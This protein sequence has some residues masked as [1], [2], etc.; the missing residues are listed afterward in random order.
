MDPA[1]S[2][3]RGG[4]FCSRRGTALFLYRFGML[5]M[6]FKRFKAILVGVLVIASVS[7]C[8]V[9]SLAGSVASVAIDVTGAVVVTGI[10]AT[11]AAIDVVAGD[12]D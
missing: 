6:G 10:K 11:G 3:M 12:D 9:I 7:G 4:Y 2:R 8:G 5:F 1:R